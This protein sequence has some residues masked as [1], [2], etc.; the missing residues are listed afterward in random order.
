MPEPV[1][2]SVVASTIA[3]AG[4]AYKS[5]KSLTNFIDSLT[6]APKLIVELKDDIKV[7][8]GLVKSIELMLENRDDRNLPRD[9]R[10]CLSSAKVPLEDCRAVS[11]S[12]ERTLEDWF[13]N[14]KSDK[15]KAN[16][17]ETKVQNFRR[18]LADTRSALD[19]ALN[20]CSM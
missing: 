9:L 5:T 19:L 7:V 11:E 3:I 10:F 1:T 15:L 8:Q 20:V 17:K 18:R 12:F 6:N 13:N 16:R 4:L 2:L 14:S